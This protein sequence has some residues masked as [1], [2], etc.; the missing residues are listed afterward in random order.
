[1]DSERGLSSV[2]LLPNHGRNQRQTPIRAFFTVKLRSSCCLTTEILCDTQ[3]K[4]LRHVT[5]GDITNALH[6]YVTDVPAKP[7]VAAV[8]PK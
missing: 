2:K 5:V 8:I 4:P 1:M 6:T 3:E 7:P